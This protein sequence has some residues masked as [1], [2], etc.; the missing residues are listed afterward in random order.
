MT[1][2][3]IAA[4][5]AGLLAACGA[6]PAPVAL[7]NQAAPDAR[8]S[9]R[10]LHDL[11]ADAE[12]HARVLAT[13][14]APTAADHLALVTAVDATAPDH[15]ITIVDAPGPGAGEDGLAHFLDVDGDHRVDLALVEQ[16]FYGPSQGFAIFVRDPDGFRLAFADPGTFVGFEPVGDHVVLR[17]EIEVLAGGEPRVIRALD[18]A[19]RRRAWTAE[20]TSFVALQGDVPVIVP[21]GDLQLAA[22]TH[23][24]LAPIIDDTATPPGDDDFEKTKTLRGN[25]LA[26]Y[27]AGARGVVLAAR[28]D[29]LFVALAADP[30]PTQTSLQHGLFMQDDEASGAVVSSLPRGTFYCGWIPR[31]ATR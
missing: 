3:R 18:Y 24:R 8:P 11:R 25:V 10:A 9:V 2:L 7:H 31:R 15:A 16:T 22:A 28:G 13:Q 12:A 27:G 1:E 20:P 4:A 6:A 21:A 19:P 23:L 26:D 17:F 29:W 5:A 30:A 14:I